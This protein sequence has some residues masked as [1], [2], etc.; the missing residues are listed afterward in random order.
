MGTDPYQEV[1]PI[2]PGRDNCVNSPPLGVICTPPTVLSDNNTGPTNPDLMK[3]ADGLQFVAW[4]DNRLF[5]AL[6]KMKRYNNTFEV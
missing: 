5:T 3:S 1:L 6:L 2:T 4:D